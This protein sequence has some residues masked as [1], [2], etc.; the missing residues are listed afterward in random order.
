MNEWGVHGSSD[1]RTEVIKTR[2]LA[3]GFV[4]VSF[5]MKDG[6][7]MNWDSQVYIMNPS[8]TTA[9]SLTSFSNPQSNRT[10]QPFG[11]SLSIISVRI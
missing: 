6:G 7:E 3:F 8:P 10:L 4:Y 1:G 11:D 5:S 9:F 2:F